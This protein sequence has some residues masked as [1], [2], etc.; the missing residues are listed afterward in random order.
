MHLTEW[1]RYYMYK[2]YQLSRL[3]P[4]SKA[5]ADISQVQEFWVHGIAL[6]LEPESQRI[7]WQ[8]DWRW[9]S[10]TLS[11]KIFM[12]YVGNLFLLSFYL[13]TLAYGSIGRIIE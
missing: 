13:Y 9:N 1:K 7:K 8:F 5:V 2:N 10:T 4:Y 3:A 11:V 6:M 12:L